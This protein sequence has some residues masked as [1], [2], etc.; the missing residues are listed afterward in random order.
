MWSERS[1]RRSAVHTH[2]FTYTH[3]CADQPLKP[4]RHFLA[5]LR[6]R[7]YGT[8]LEAIRSAVIFDVDFVINGGKD[9][10]CV[11]AISMNMHSHTRIFV[12]SSAK[13]HFLRIR[14][15]GTW[16]L[17]AELLCE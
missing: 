10:H 9:G 7:K 4:K 3:L 6:I 16:R 5:A 2:T 8:G 15:Y 14:T 1:L 12:C 11:S 17:F 13:R